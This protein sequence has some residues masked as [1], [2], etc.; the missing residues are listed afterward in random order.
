MKNKNGITLVS[1][2]VTIIVLIILAGVSINLTLGENGIITMAKKARENMELA[3]VDEE[4][5]LNELYEQIV[6]EGGSSGNESDDAII[7]LAQFKKEI[8]SALTD[9]GIET[10]ENADASTMSNNIRSLTGSSS[11]DKVSYDNTNSG[12][13][14]TNVQGAVDELNNSLGGLRFGVDGEGNYG[15]FGADDS[16]IPFNKFKKAY[17]FF[18]I[19]GIAARCITITS[20][21]TRYIVCGAGNVVDE[22]IK[23]V[24][25]NIV[26]NEKSFV[27]ISTP[28]DVLLEN[29]NTIG[30]METTTFNPNDVI[31]N[32]PKEN[33]VTIILVQ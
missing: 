7:R 24:S 21:E 31:G 1:L 26:C 20:E 28:L 13:T 14:A 33:H 10:A 9:M 18:A 12:L 8:A 11:A 19:S 29:T 30:D 27:G 5:Q 16:L 6:A 32:M 17:I 4:R 25:N 2:V 22:Y 23:R 15:Y 3:K